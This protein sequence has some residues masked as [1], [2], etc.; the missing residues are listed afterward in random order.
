M[1]PETGSS[2]WRRVLHSSNPNAM[3]TFTKNSIFTNAALTDEGDIWWEEMGVPA[4]AHAIDWEGNDWSPDTGKKAAHPERALH[5]SGIA[6]SG[7][8]SR[9]GEPGRRPSFG[10]P[11]WRPAG[12]HCASGV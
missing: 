9:L 6:V 12:G 8:R 11:V 7:D 5:S 3:E 1:N 2:G 10:H 4:P